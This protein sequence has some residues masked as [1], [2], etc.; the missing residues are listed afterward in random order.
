VD[1]DIFFAGVTGQAAAVRSGDLSSRELVAATLERIQRYDGRFN[2]F[3]NVL[4]DAALAE[5]AERDAA[6]AV[7][8][9]PLHGVP[10][11]IKEEID[12][13]GTVTT[14]GGRANVTP[15]A[16]DSEVVRRLRAAGAIVVAK[17][18]LSEWAIGG[19][20]HNRHFGACRNP[21]D[22][23]RVSGGSSSGSA[24]AAADLVPL[25]IGTDTGGSL[26]VP[27][28][29]CGVTAMRPAV[30]RVSD[31]GTVPVS[32]T[33]DT[34]GPLARRASDVALA[35]EAIAGPLPGDQTHASPRGDLAEMRIGVL[36]GALRDGCEPA[37][38]TVLE[39]ATADLRSLGARV[40]SV[41]LTGVDDAV[42]AMAVVM[43]SDAAA[44]HETRLQQAHDHF[45]P[46]IR[47]RL[48]RGRA[49]TG[50]DYAR[51]RQEQRRFRRTVMD[52]LDRWDVL[53]APAAPTVAPPVD[54]TDPL[55]AT[56]TL[57]RFAAPLSLTRLPIVSLPCGFTAGGLPAGAQLLGGPGSEQQLLGLAATYQAATSWHLRPCPAVE[58]S[59]ASV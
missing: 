33:L 18:N 3:T 40:E 13:A 56:G 48:Q 15:A 10:V 35:L 20:G 52:A 51:A 55:A 7:G 53:M 54:G 47:E 34:V 36:T 49:T 41:E 38:D 16:A 39:R 24:A 30:G 22:R 2:A 59:D 46:D 6:P 58:P 12:V 31:R 14:Y 28:A 8:R 1:D 23:T 44:V 57:M 42:E 5:A 26:R 11:A 45:A 29:L 19:T 9:G 4:H 21:W 37:V 27:A 50:T 17:L 43:L 25:T 32:W